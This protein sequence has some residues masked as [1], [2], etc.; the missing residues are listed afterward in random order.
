MAYDKD[1]DERR[2]IRFHSETLALSLGA[3]PDAME[4]STMLAKGGRHYKLGG[5][6]ESVG[7]LT[8]SEALRV[9]TGAIATV[10]LMNTWEKVGDH[11]AIA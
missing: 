9:L 3:H 8:Y 1:R 10:D 4:P 7:W 11:A 5:Y 6:L 2:T